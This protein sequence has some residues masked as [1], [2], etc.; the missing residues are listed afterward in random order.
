MCT[1]VR[2]MREVSRTEGKTE[3]REEMAKELL[4]DG[5]YSDEKIAAISKLPLSKIQ[6]LKKEIQ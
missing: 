5:A 1:A 4:L 2:E 3:A 6:E